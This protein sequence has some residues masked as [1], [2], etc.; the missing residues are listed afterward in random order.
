M[1]PG[2][3]P[4]EREAHPENNTLTAVPGVE[5]GHWTHPSGTT[6]TTAILFPE[7]AVGG[8]VVPG[9]APGSRELGVL[10]PHHLA[11]RVHGFC[12]SGGSAF[13]LAAADGVVAVLRERGIGFPVGAH[14]I[15]LVPAAILFD[16]PVAAVQPDA[17]SG[18]AAARAA[19]T[20]P[21]ARGRVGAGAG[22][23]VGKAA[24]R[25]VPGGFGTAARDW[26]Q[27]R[28][29]A[30]VAVNAYGSVRDPET[31]RWLAGGPF[32]AG[33]AELGGNTTLAVVA[34]DAPLTKAQCQVVAQMATAGLARTLV[35][36]FTPVDGDTVFV[37]STGQ[38]PPLEPLALGAL[39]HA[40]AEVLAA[41]VLD[42]V[43]RA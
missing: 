21:L 15:P 39:G 26:G 8:V 43:R 40:A 31:G 36:A 38:G 13:G 32:A 28:V 7:G 24:G 6:G 34:T 33:A 1:E 29:G 42:S 9:S 4:G 17:A 14:C 41:A 25:T 18:R 27:H 11:D 12:L 2:A 20:A 19:S 10:A 16:L 35:P 3:E 22:A 5:A 30:G 37:A 23:R